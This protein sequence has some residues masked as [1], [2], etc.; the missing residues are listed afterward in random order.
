MEEWSKNQYSDTGCRHCEQCL[1]PLS[2]ARS[3]DPSLVIPEERLLPTPRHTHHNS[4]D[5]VIFL[6]LKKKNRN[7]EFYRVLKGV[8]NEQCSRNVRLCCIVI[9][10]P[11]IYCH[12]EWQG[13]VGMCSAFLVLSPSNPFFLFF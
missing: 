10:F 5:S 6:H 13:T 9:T 1:H 7:V 4:S 12:H 8:Y 2:T 11:R 3:H